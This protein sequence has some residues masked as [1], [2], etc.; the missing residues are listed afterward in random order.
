MKIKDTKE[1][2][3]KIWSYLRV[4]TPVMSNDSKDEII[5]RFIGQFGLLSTLIKESTGQTPIT[6]TKQEQEFIDG[7][8]EAFYFADTGEEDQ[9]ENDAELSDMARRTITIDCLAFIVQYGNYLDVVKADYRQ[10]GHDFYFTRNGHGVGFWDRP[11][12]YGQ[13]ADTLTKGSDFF[14]DTHYYQGDDGLIYC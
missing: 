14:G 4:V 10:A 9:P 2:R 7:Y 1:N 8:I 5:D 12:F 6:P 3:R 11:E 13:Y